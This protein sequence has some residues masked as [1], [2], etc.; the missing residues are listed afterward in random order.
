MVR[1]LLRE[2]FQHAV[3]VVN[4][5]PTLRPQTKVPT[6]NLRFEVEFFSWGFGFL[7]FS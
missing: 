2:L 4:L 3:R 7:S 5:H 6:V 1:S